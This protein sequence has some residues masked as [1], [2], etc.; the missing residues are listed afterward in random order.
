MA[1]M[2]NQCSSSDGRI[3]K[4]IRIRDGFQ[5]NGGKSIGNPSWFP[6]TRVLFWNFHT[7]NPLQDVFA[8]FISRRADFSIFGIECKHRTI[9]FSLQ[10]LAM[11][12]SHRI[13]VV[14]V[15]FPLL[16]RHRWRQTAFCLYR[17]WMHWNGLYLFSFATKWSV[18]GGSKEDTQMICLMHCNQCYLIWCNVISVLEIFKDRQTFSIDQKGNRFEIFNGDLSCVYQWMKRYEECG[19]YREVAISRIQKA[20]N[21]ESNREG[22]EIE[23]MARLLQYKQ[24]YGRELKTNRSTVIW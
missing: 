24:V 7:A 6:V 10:M 18:I 20:M 4:Q 16:Q 21:W 1:L 3:D 22:R 17:N 23:N 12:F 9:V 13:C 14:I 5:L 2:A 8:A 19:W 15:S 11:A